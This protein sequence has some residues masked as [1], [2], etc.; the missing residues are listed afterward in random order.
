M[1]L[2][3]KSAAKKSFREATS[4]VQGV[5]DKI[6]P[7]GAKAPGLLDDN[8]WKLTVGALAAV[9]FL[10]FFSAANGM[11]SGLPTT[12]AS[13]NSIAEFDVGSDGTLVKVVRE[14]DPNRNRYYEIE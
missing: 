3:A 7:A 1:S 5:N 2:T 6:F 8:G 10:A 14:L 9:L 12:P 11:K 4:V 13:K